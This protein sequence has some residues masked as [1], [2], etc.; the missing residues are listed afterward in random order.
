MGSPQVN[1]D[2]APSLCQS[3]QAC[4]TPAPL[5]PP[6]RH[7][8]RPCAARFVTMA[9]VLCSCACPAPLSRCPDRMS[10]GWVGGG[11]LL[12]LPGREGERAVMSHTQSLFL[13]LLLLRRRVDNVVC[14]LRP[15]SEAYF[16]PLFC[17]RWHAPFS[18]GESGT[19][20]F[21]KFSSACGAFQ[22]TLSTKKATQ[23]GFQK[24]GQDLRFHFNSSAVELLLP[25]Q[26]KQLV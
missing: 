9:R 26:K 12:L 19:E 5:A 20:F 3:S 13:L 6:L 18:L 17:T 4:A 8:R 24:K 11:N 15:A 23:K 2:L 10:F 1:R 21:T 16:L 25:P 14:V 7:L 22:V